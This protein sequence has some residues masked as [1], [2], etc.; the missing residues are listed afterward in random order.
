MIKKIR[1]GLAGAICFNSFLFEDQKHTG[2][3][4]QHGFNRAY[5]PPGEPLELDAGI[6]SA[7]GAIFRKIRIGGLTADALVQMQT[8]L[9]GE[10]MVVG[11]PCSQFIAAGLAGLSGIDAGGLTG[12]MGGKFLLLAAAF[13]GIVVPLLIHSQNIGEIVGSGP[14]ETAGIAGGIAAAVKAVELQ[15]AALVTGFTGEPV[16]LLVGGPGGRKAVN[17][18]QSGLQSAGANGTDLG[19][20]RGSGFAGDVG[21]RIS[22]IAA[23]VTDLVVIPGIVTHL[24]GI[25]VLQHLLQTAAGTAVAVGAFIHLFKSGEAMSGD[26]DFFY[27]GGAAVLTDHIL[28]ACFGTGGGLGDGFH[29]PFMI[30]G[31]L[32]AADRAFALV[33]VFVDGFPLFIFVVFA[34]GDLFFLG[35][36][37]GGALVAGP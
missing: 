27:L 30:L 35:L 10:F 22:G 6:G 31:G 23:A 2:N 8:V 33:G 24:T 15:T 25:A 29:H 3:H 1:P 21:G 12:Y 11:Q 32:L 34:L 7:D 17:M 20:F 28:A 4:Q 5:D 36:S 14:L 37:A 26:G 9:H 19:R 13:A 18:V 16:G